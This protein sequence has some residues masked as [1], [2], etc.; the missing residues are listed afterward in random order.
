MVSAIVGMAVT[1]DPGFVIAAFAYIHIEAIYPTNP[2]ILMGP[3][4]QWE[5]RRCFL[6]S[7]F[8]PD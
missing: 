3:A 4:M 7:V 6:S 1:G 2:A 5:V 8:F